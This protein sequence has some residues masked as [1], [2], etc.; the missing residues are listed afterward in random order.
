M[1]SWFQNPVPRLAAEAED[2]RMW[3]SCLLISLINIEILTVSANGFVILL[4]VHS[5]IRS[6][7][8]SLPFPRERIFLPLERSDNARFNVG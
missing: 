6:H 7:S 1:V 2:E 4:I 8:A 3:L 5:Y